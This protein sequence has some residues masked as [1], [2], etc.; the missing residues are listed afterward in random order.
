ML[1]DAIAKLPGVVEIHH[2][3]EIADEMQ[4]E[5]LDDD[6]DRVF[7]TPSSLSFIGRSTLL[8]PTKKLSGYQ[9]DDLFWKV[10]QAI[11][12]SG[13]ICKLKKVTGADLDLIHWS[14]IAGSIENYCIRALSGLEC[15]S[16]HFKNQAGA[17]VTRL[18]TFIA[19]MPK[20]KSLELLLAY[21]QVK[22]ELDPPRPMGIY[23]T[24]FETFRMVHLHSLMISPWEHLKSLVLAGMIAT[25]ENIRDV[26]LKHA[27][28][29]RELE[30]LAVEL[31]L[32][33]V[34]PEYSRDSMVKLICSLN[35]SANL[36]YVVFDDVQTSQEDIWA[37]GVCQARHMA[38][39][40]SRG[41]CE[42]CISIAMEIQDNE[43]PTSDCFPWIFT[44]K[45][46]NFDRQ[47]R[48]LTSICPYAAEHGIT[49]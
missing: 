42:G 29:L 19:G 6:D 48:D 12:L 38:K 10:L 30:L 14:D 31:K 5:D 21:E 45:T 35:L 20:L 22:V 43:F 9:H 8:E 25:E 37:A 40:R 11:C 4:Q 47:S 17:D 24:Q 1:M 39:Y 18:S 3:A 7:P 23:K 16:L 33:T 41:Y 44:D 49:E 26:L 27:T 32:T 46:G 2:T 34:A 13:L 15:L 28:T 36:E